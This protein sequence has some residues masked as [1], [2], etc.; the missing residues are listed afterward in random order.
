MDEFCVKE[1]SRICTVLDG[2]VSRPLKIAVPCCL[3]EN[4]LRFST[5]L[6]T[7]LDAS[8][9]AHN[10]SLKMASFWAAQQKVNFLVLTKSVNYTVE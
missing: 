8:F 7:I 1:F 4:K 10:A 2:K 5:V 6:Y 3:V 9:K